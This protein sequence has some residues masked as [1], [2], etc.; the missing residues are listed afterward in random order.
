[1]R[2]RRQA[3][4]SLP[5]GS[6]TKRARAP[7]I[8]SGS[9]EYRSLNHCARFVFLSRATKGYTKPTLP[10]EQL[11]GSPRCTQ[12]PPRSEFERGLPPCCFKRCRRPLVIVPQSASLSGRTRAAAAAASEAPVAS[13]VSASL[14]ASWVILNYTVSRQRVKFFAGLD[15]VSD[16]ALVG[17][18]TT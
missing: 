6:R 18:V 7:D 10:P 14:C 4:N 15:R 8:A 16:G 13:S 1:M 9:N 11:K 12:I 2:T 5:W 3:F 17:S